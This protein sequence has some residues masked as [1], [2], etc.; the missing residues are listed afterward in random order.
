VAETQPA[1]SR[2]FE[3]PFLMR[4]FSLILENVDGTDDLEHKFVFRSTQHTLAMLQNALTPSPT[5][6]CFRV[7]GT[8]TERTGWGGDGAP[9]GV[10]TL[11]DG[12]IHNAQG[13]LKDFMIGAIIQHYPRTL[14]RRPRTDPNQPFDSFDFRLPT[15][16]ELNALEAFQRSLGRRE[17]P[18][19]RT[20]QLKGDSPSRGQGLFNDPAVGKCAGCHLNAGASFPPIPGVNANF[21]TGVENIPNRPTDESGA[22]IPRDG[23]FGER[24]DGA[25]GP[26][27]PQPGPC[28]TNG[29]GNGT[30]NVQV[31]VEAADTGPFFHNNAVNTIEDAVAFYTSAAFNTSPAAAGAIG[32]INLS[33]AQVID[34]AAFLRVLNTLEN[35]RSAGDLDKR[36]KTANLTQGRELIR[37]AISELNDALGVLAGGNLHPNAQGVLSDALTL[38]QNAFNTANLQTRN[39][40]LDDAIAKMHVAVDHMVAVN[41]SAFQF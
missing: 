30:F 25:C 18:D 22:P 28:P 8:A 23:G 24:P 3:N 13:T 2:N 38:N 37:L 26:P 14:A 9:V 31:L 7:P 32:A 34:I 5:D 27:P 35:I 40:L 33:S 20:L 41:V 16:A 15:Q 19:L 6:P 21:N 1:L 12:V 36:A 29:C 39:V 4:R 17:D 10:F 11:S